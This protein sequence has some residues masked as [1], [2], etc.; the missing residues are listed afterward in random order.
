MN[1]VRVDGT[2][3]EQ[4]IRLLELVPDQVIK[5]LNQNGM[6]RDRNTD[7]AVAV[8]SVKNLTR[9]GGFINKG[10]VLLNRHD[11]A[12]YHHDGRWWLIQFYGEEE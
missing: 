3:P 9:S 4:C 8:T 5:I 10:F 2:Y 1:H 6:V 7:E 12:L 11:T